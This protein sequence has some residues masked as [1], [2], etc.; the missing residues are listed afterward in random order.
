MQI[1][2]HP[3]VDDPT[4]DDPTVDYLTFPLYSSYSYKMVY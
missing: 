2:D 4:V 3:P 1:V